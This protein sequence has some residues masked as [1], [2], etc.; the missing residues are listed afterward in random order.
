MAFLV[1][2]GEDKVLDEFLAK[3]RQEELCCHHTSQVETRKL[4]QDTM[5]MDWG[6]C[7]VVHPKKAKELILQVIPFSCSSFNLNILHHTHKLTH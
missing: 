5:R 4:V 3:D 2:L 7:E 6:R 1:F